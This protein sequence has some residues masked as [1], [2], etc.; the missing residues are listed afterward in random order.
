MIL[1]FALVYFL[2]SMLIFHNFHTSKLAKP[3]KEDPRLQVNSKE[4]VGS[5]S[6]RR[7]PSQRTHG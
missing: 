4:P 5:K 3:K 7:R 6:Q 2:G 1:L